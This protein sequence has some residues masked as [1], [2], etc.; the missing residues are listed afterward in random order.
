[1]L[2][3]DSDAMHVQPALPEVG[4]HGQDGLPVGGKL[5]LAGVFRATVL[6][7]EDLMENRIVFIMLISPKQQK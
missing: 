1:M 3:N 2:Q 4:V 5:W 6:E 7:G